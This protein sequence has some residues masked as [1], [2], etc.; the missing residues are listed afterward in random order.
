MAKYP[1]GWLCYC[2]HIKSQHKIRMRYP[3]RSSVCLEI[4]YDCA[5][6]FTPYTISH[7][8]IFEGTKVNH[9]YKPIDNLSYVEYLEKQKGVLK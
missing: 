1:K 4:C 5:A 2:G 3:R 9:K 7:A 8:A 6:N